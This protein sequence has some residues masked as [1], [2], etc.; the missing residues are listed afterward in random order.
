MKN[1]LIKKRSNGFKTEKNF[2]N[3]FLCLNNK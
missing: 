3:N 2:K 1:L